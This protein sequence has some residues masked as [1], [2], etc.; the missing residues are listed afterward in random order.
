MNG[1]CQSKKKKP[2]PFVEAFQDCL[3]DSQMAN[4]PVRLCTAEEYWQIPVFKLDDAAHWTLSI[5]DTEQADRFKP[6]A[7]KGLGG[8]KPRTS[9]PCGE[10]LVP[11]FGIADGEQMKYSKGHFDDP[12]GLEHSWSTSSTYR[13]CTRSK[14]YADDHHAYEVP[15]PERDDSSEPLVKSLLKAY[16]TKGKPKP[17]SD[18]FQRSAFGQCYRRKDK[19][20][21]FGEAQQYC[22]KHGGQ[23]CNV[24]Q[25]LLIER[26]ALAQDATYH[27]SSV[28]D[29][30]HTSRFEPNI[31]TGPDSAIKAGPLGQGLKPI[32]GHNDGEAI[33]YSGAGSLVAGTKWSVEQPVVCC[34]E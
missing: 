4:R 18:A 6:T 17:C 33:S 27:T 1:I 7:P 20:M 14:Y 19:S 15:M 5:Q 12:N 25:Y 29:V 21:N 2:S 30:R 26:S 22:W 32:D 10:G 24:Q 23:V 8:V 13:C 28:P 34:E 11:T 3:D 16:K 9:T 31:P